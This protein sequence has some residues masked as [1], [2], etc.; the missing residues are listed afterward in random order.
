[1][2]EGILQ[3]EMMKFYQSPLFLLGLVIILSGVY[4]TVKTMIDIQNWGMLYGIPALIAG[5]VLIIIHLLINWLI[6]TRL[7]NLVFIELCVAAILFVV[8]LTVL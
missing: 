7:R 6:K 8:F 3:F 5:G 4:Y 1:M 2:A